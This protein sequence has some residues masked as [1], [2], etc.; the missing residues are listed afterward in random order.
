MQKIKV[1]FFSHLSGQRWIGQHTRQGNDGSVNAPG[2]VGIGWKRTRRRRG[3]L[4]THMAARWRGWARTRRRGGRTGNAQGGVVA[5]QGTHKAAWRRGGERTRRRGG[6]TGNAQGG[7]AARRGLLFT[8]CTL[9]LFLVACQPLERTPQ[10]DSD[11][12]LSAEPYAFGGDFTLIDH[13]GN[14]FRLAEQQRP[15]FLFLGYA[16]CPDACPQTLARLARV[17]ALL[18][19]EARDLGTLFVSVDA[20]R[21]SPAVLKTYLSHFDVP[22]IGL[23][24]AQDSIDAVV[25]RYA[26]HYEINDQASAAGYL[27]DHSLYIYLIDQHGDSRFFFRPS[28]TAEEIATVARQ[29]FR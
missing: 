7:E 28:H 14:A 22:A 23:T 4:G 8:L 26:A 25:K 21:D 2:G 9:H 12:A 5:G 19:E 1:L 13:D 17:Y 10:V 29:L 18:G 6:R 11:L 20:E 27:I 16:S 15:F 24:G 3:R